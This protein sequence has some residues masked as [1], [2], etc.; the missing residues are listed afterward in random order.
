[1]FPASTV[2]LGA[3][4]GLVAT[5]RD[6]GRTLCCRT[7]ATA[8]NVS[9]PNAAVNASLCALTAN[10]GSAATRFDLRASAILACE[11]GR[12]V[13]GRAPDRCGA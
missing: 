11:C 10:S 8:A 7:H 4:L 5:K 6:H 12:A 13:V 2:E 9:S 1:M 3:L